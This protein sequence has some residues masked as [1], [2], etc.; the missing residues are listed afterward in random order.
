MWALFGK[1]ASQHGY[2]P[3]GNYPCH[4][5]NY[6]SIP[7]VNV[8][9][10]GEY[11]S[12]WVSPGGKKVDFRTS[13]SIH[14]LNRKNDVLEKNQFEKDSIN[15]MDLLNRMGIAQKSPYRP[16]Q[17]LLQSITGDIMGMTL[18]NAL[19]V[20]G[21]ARVGEHGPAWEEGI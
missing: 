2:T 11:N 8:G 9:P 4:E 21:L 1:Y 5:H 16:K 13:N 17:E 6:P 19:E 12:Q 7:H 3:F 15:R 14:N 18:D 10:Q 20:R